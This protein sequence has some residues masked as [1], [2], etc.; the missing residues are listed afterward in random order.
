MVRIVV[1]RNANDCGVAALSTLV[2]MDYDVVAATAPRGGQKGLR[3]RELVATA[4]RLGITLTAVRA[5]DLDV[6]AGVLRVRSHAHHRDGHWVTVRY[7]LIFNPHDGSAR[8]WREY[9][10]KYR[11]RFGLL[12]RL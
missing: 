1:Q 12:A 10:T 5:Y 9:Q 8:P 6:D 11:A 2:A 3:T 7:G 4:R